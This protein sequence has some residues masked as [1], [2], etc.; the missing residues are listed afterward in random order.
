MNYWII[1]EN[2]PLFHSFSYV[3]IISLAPQKY[4]F[5]H[6]I[7]RIILLCRF[8]IYI[9]CKPRYVVNSPLKFWRD[10][11]RRIIGVWLFLSLVGTTFNIQQIIILCIFHF[12]CIL[13]SQFCV[14]IIVAYMELNIRWKDCGFDS[15]ISSSIV[16]IIIFIRIPR[17]GT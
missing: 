7:K 13:V 4:F 8:K 11:I 5:V 10:L 14:S 2:V 1:F 15:S 12:T 16:I 17:I 6:R 9:I 3:A